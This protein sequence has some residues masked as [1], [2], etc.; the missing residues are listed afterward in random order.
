MAIKIITQPLQE[1]V[2]LNEA[3]LHL[4]VDSSDEDAL[5]ASLILTARKYCEEYQNRAYAQQGLELTLDD[6]PR[7][8]EPIVISRPPLISVE[9]AKYYGTDNMEYTWNPALYYVDAD[10]EPG[11]ISPNYSEIYPTMTL[12]PVSGVKIRYTAGYSPIITTKTIAASELPIAGTVINFDGSISVTVLNTDGDATVTTTDYCANV[13]KTV[14][15]AILLL[16]G[17]WYENREAAMDKA[18]SR[19]VDF[20]VGALLGL[21]RV[22]PI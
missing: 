19:D 3:K 4:R 16:V 8:A 5:I 18:T 7:G 11:R 22:I 14:K 21:D 13:P 6:W 17:H 10:S 12:R 20:S 15:Q 9:S 1:P 2:T